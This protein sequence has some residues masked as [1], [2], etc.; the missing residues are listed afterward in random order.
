MKRLIIFMFKFGV[1]MRLPVDKYSIVIL[2]K[3]AVYMLECLSAN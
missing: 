3:Y 2:D 1:G